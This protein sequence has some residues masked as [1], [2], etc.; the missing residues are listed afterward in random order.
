[1]KAR[2]RFTTGIIIGGIV[3]AICALIGAFFC[4]AKL[5]GLFNLY[6]MSTFIDVFGCVL[7]LIIFVMVIILLTSSNYKFNDT[8][9]VLSLI[10]FKQKLSY[11]YIQLIRVDDSKNFFLVY[12]SSE[13][14]PE[15][16]RFLPIYVGKAKSDVIKFMQD[17]NR[18]II[19]ETN[20]KES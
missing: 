8:H 1:M 20:V 12:Y 16:I 3:I 14:K 7:C 5:L 15:E 17:K 11:N 4:L 10:L 19:V 13:E 2:F 6:S 18:N 9:L